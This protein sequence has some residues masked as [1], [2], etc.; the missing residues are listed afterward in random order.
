MLKLFRT[1]ILLRSF[2]FGLT[3][4][5]GGLAAAPATAIPASG[6]RNI[7][8]NRSSSLCMGVAGGDVTDGKPLIMWRCNRNAD[9]TW[10]A[11]SIVLGPLGRSGP[12]LLRNGTNRD[13]C[14]SVAN[15]STNDGAALVIWF[16]KPAIANQDQRWRFMDDPVTGCTVIVNANSQKVISPR[17][18]TSDEGT[19][20]VQFT[21]LGF[22]QQQ[23]CIGEA[24]PPA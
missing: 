13:K 18:W 20:I 5:A 11:E 3:V 4:V 23:W 16:C 9:Q 2:T 1:R 10:I 21:Y 14:L 15:K 17:T 24:P 22:V 7:W 12:F 6:D 8:T 19:P